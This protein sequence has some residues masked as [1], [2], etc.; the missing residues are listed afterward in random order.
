M[1]SNIDKYLPLVLQAAGRYDLNPQY[2]ANQIFQE[3]RFNPS[4]RSKAGAVGI[5][6]FLPTTAQQLGINPLDPTQAI[7]AAARMMAGHLKTY[8]GDYAKTLASYNAGPG[9]V[10]KYNGVPPY[11]E[12]QNYIHNIMNKILVQLPQN[13]SPK[14][15]SIST[16]PTVVASRGGFFDRGGYSNIP[17]QFSGAFTGL[18]QNGVSDQN[19]SA[20][21]PPLPQESAPVLLHGNVEQNSVPDSPQFTAETSKEPH[22]M[23]FSFLWPALIGAGIGAGK[24]ALTHHN[25]LG[26]ALGG[27][28]GGGIAGF[29]GAGNFG[30]NLSAGLSGGL[31]GPLGGLSFQLGHQANNNSN[32]IGGGSLPPLPSLPTAPAQNTLP[33]DMNNDQIPLRTYQPPAAPN[34]SLGF[35]PTTVKNELKDVGT[36]L[37]K[38]LIATNP[39]RPL[40]PSLQPLQTSQL[41]PYQIQS[42]TMPQNYGRAI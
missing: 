32:P 21:L 3:S 26:G 9:A 1:A 42:L 25:V 39:A 15:L 4:A 30:S 27:G 16:R 14:N 12:T 13:L 41:L 6:Q 23:G 29:G 37:V 19:G 2:F 36:N 20:P 18:L 5:A 28:I 40:V 17:N 10:Q 33:S 31:G 24:A 7:E 34:P 22:N 35:N 8:G 38:H 11:R